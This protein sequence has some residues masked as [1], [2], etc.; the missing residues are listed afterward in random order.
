M[1]APVNFPTIAK[2]AERTYTQAEVE[3][4]FA[5]A[6]ATADEH[7]VAYRELFQLAYIKGRFLVGGA[8]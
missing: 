3:Q 4:I 5:E 1:S 6:E 2:K 8:E 7:G